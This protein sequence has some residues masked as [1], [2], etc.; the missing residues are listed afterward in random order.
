MSQT[1]V[2]SVSS[3]YTPD[4]IHHV[5]KSDMPKVGPLILKMIGKMESKVFSKSVSRWNKMS[6]KEK[7]TFNEFV[8]KLHIG[9]MSLGFIG[10]I[11][12]LSNTLFFSAAT[13]VCT[14]CIPL[15]FT[16]G[17]YFLTASPFLAMGNAAYG[18]HQVHKDD[19][20]DLYERA[21]NYMISYCTKYMD[22]LTI[23][24]EEGV[25]IRKAVT[26]ILRAAGTGATGP[27]SF[28]NDAN[29]C[30]LSAI[31]LICFIRLPGNSD[32]SHKMA[33]ASSSG[34]TSGLF[35]GAAS[36]FSRLN[37]ACISFITSTVLP[38]ANRISSAANF[39]SP[40]TLDETIDEID[41]L[42]ASPDAQTCESQDLRDEVMGMDSQM[43]YSSPERSHPYAFVSSPEKTF[44]SRKRAHSPST[45]SS[46]SPECPARR[47]YTIHRCSS[48]KKHGK[49]RRTVRRK[50]V[51]EE[52]P[53]DVNK[54]SA[55]VAP[56]AA[57]AAAATNALSTAA[58]NVTPTSSESISSSPAEAESPAAE[59]SPAESEPSSEPSSEQ[60][61]SQASVDGG[62][63]R[64]RS[65]KQRKN[66]GKQKSAR[67]HRRH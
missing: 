29:N 7:D 48:P 64:R 2:A 53:E 10:G 60:S 5:I 8:L 14:M 21:A 38:T 59:S 17:S 18:T 62:R 12:F 46:S 42:T 43:Q 27:M 31:W 3:L 44:D 26:K 66:A 16:I 22:T 34:T 4:E 6:T 52:Q 55:E 41:R 61:P 11:G 25:K 30:I 49:K 45:A 39:K 13:A 35:S 67:R 28:F 9:F 15:L 20:D 1:S 54:E 51:H 56:A 65:N 36:L 19:Q 50:L 57:V 47:K 23:S 33:S 40:G 37:T 32:I 24:G 58:S 63:R